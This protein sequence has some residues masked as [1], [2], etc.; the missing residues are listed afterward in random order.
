MLTHRSLAMKKPEH[1][2]GIDSGLLRERRRLRFAAQP[3][4]RLACL[5]LAHRLR[6][7]TSLLYVRC[8]IMSRRSSIA[9]LNS[10]HS[11]QEKSYFALWAVARGSKKI[12]G[13]GSGQVRRRADRRRVVPMPSC[14]LTV[15]REMPWGW[16]ARAPHRRMRALLPRAN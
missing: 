11:S 10:R 8:D 1:I 4:D 12:Q 14:V 13:G 7:P 15:P 5:R 16:R 3:D 9:T 6:L 2:P